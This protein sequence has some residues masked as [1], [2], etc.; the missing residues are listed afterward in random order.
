MGRQTSWSV[1]SD[2]LA[3]G[4]NMVRG[5]TPELTRWP[6]GSLVECGLATDYPSIC[7]YTFPFAEYQEGGGVLTVPGLEAVSS[8]DYLP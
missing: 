2:T 1:C 6:D 5:V 3:T 8:I 7:A 4:S